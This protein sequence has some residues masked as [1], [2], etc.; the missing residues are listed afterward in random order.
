ME[1]WKVLLILAALP[2]AGA[3]YLAYENGNTLKAQIQNTISQTKRETNKKEEQE[4]KKT[5]NS[6]LEA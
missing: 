3:A 2:V 5:K 4:D 6:E 1:P